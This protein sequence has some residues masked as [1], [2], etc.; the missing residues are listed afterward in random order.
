MQIP[1]EAWNLKSSSFFQLNPGFGLELVWGGW[2]DQLQH[3]E[4]LMELGMGNTRDGSIL[5]IL[6]SVASSL[7]KT[8]I[9]GCSITSYSNLLKILLTWC[10]VFCHSGR[11]YWNQWRGWRWTTRSWSC[12]KQWRTEGVVIKNLWRLFS[13]WMTISCFFWFGGVFRL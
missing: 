10:W 13:R 12:Q 6:A 2:K 5:L 8:K 11:S 9:T 4:D 3:F 1:W 7:W